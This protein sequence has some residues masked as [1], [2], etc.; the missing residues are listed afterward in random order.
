MLRNKVLS[1]M[2]VII[3]L[4]IG[5]IVYFSVHPENWLKRS[6][7]EISVKDIEEKTKDNYIGLKAGSDIPRVTT[8]EEFLS[9]SYKEYVTILADELIPTQIY[10]RKNWIKET[11]T[12]KV[13]TST[14]RLRT[15]STHNPLIVTNP[16][17]ALENYYEYYL[18]RLADDSYI[19]VIM[20]ERDAKK[21]K[22]G[23]EV[24]LPIGI[25]CQIPAEAEGYLEK[26]NEEYEIITKY[27]LYTIEDDWHKKAE[28]KVFFLRFGISAVVF[29]VLSV[30]MML[31]TSKIRKQES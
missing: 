28:Q 27:Y 12:R 3:S 19:P 4:I 6:E 16:L 15:S 20:D 14:G 31:L 22:E 5:G 23:K 10:Q 11:E 17:L 25:K 7:K 2:I 29:S 30:G 1:Y 8:A 18:V 26:I 9:L 21:I 24:L 13:R